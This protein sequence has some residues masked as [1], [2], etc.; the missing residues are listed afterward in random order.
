MVETEPSSPAP[1]RTK[2]DDRGVSVLRAL[3]VIALLGLVAM[4]SGRALAPALPGVAVGLEGLIAALRVGGDLLSQIYAVALLVATLSLL[5]AVLQSRASLAERSA[6]MVLGGAVLFIGLRAPALRLTPEAGVVLGAAAAGASLLAARA[7]LR[8]P[9]VARL[10]W[11]FLLLG[12][13]GILRLGAVSLG[14]WGADLPLDAAWWTRTVATASLAVDV[15]A[16]FAALFA[17]A[18]SRGRLVRPEALV[19]LALTLFATRSALLGADPEAG[20]LS[21]LAS[22]AA[23]FLGTSPGTWAAPTL[24]TFASLLGP[25]VAVTVLVVG[26]RTPLA[27]V[28]V[29]ALLARSTPDIPLCGLGLFVASAALWLA[30]REGR[31]L[32]VSLGSEMREKAGSGGPVPAPASAI[33]AAVAPGQNVAATL[34]RRPLE[35]TKAALSSRPSRRD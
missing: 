28:L 12:V 6:W 33:R 29:L 19:A 31:A 5:F 14:T 35:F 20:W 34:L 9:P 16:L 32:W 24:V 22:R 7:A 17:A 26:G 23:V 3:R 8:V 10:A 13:A 15:L 25:V 11:P 2:G 27:G 4:L 21:I 1:V 18:P 30:S